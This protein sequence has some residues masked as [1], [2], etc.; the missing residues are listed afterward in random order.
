M[1]IKFVKIHTYK[2]IKKDDI[3]HIRRLKFCY[4]YLKA[5]SYL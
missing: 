1:L 3:V 4:D 5:K 2:T